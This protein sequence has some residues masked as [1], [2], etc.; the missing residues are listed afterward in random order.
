MI[1]DTFNAPIGNEDW[2]ERT[3]QD[4]IVENLGFA[5][6]I[7]KGVADN[8]GLTLTGSNAKDLQQKNGWIGTSVDNSPYS[9]L[10]HKWIYMFGDST[11]RQIWASYAAPFQG[12]NFERNAKE[13]SRHYCNKQS[14]R[15]H[16]V[17]NGFF[18]SEGW[19]GPCGVN[20]V[21]CHVS[22]Y[23]DGGLLSFDWKHFPYEDY[24]EY[25]WSDKGP[26]ISGFSGEGNRR[27]DVL[28]I[29]FGLHSC[30][31]ASPQGLYSTHL[32]EVNASML[33]KHLADI[34]KLMDSIKKAIMIQNTTH[35]TMVIIV[36]SGSSGMS[37]NGTE[38]DDCILKF[39]RAAAISAHEHGFAVLER[40]EIERRLL[41]KSI[42]STNPILEIEMHLPQPAQNIIATSLLHLINCLNASSIMIS[43]EEKEFKSIIVN[44]KRKPPRARPLHVPPSS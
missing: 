11:T 36:T 14:A 37:H 40:G 12:N 43:E 13:W 29:Q 25:M 38:I 10:N 27:P 39:N 35:Q 44:N 4:L 21:T 31:H 33:D 26:W 2:D 42:Q 17:K 20:E 23:G 16:H 3:H 30:W 9:I 41:Y 6:W 34:P 5:P 19:G 18:P 22:G 8:N 1:T 15:T 32:H 7:A 28:T 24:D